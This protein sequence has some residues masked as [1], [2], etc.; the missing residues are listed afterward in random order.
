MKYW[1]EEMTRFTF[2][3][4]ISPKSKQ[5]GVAMF[6][7]FY[8]KEEVVNEA[9]QFVSQVS[10]FCDSKGNGTYAASFGHDDLVM[11]ELQM[12]FV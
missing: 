3:K 4:K 5:Y 7:Q 10:N 12:V 11:D 8:E 6:K 1:N 2:G 9:I